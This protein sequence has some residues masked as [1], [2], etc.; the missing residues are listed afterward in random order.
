MWWRGN[1]APLFL[2]SA[3]DGGEWS[4]SRHGRLTP[5]ERAPDIHWKGGWVGTIAFL[6]AVENRKISCPCR[7]RTAAVQPIDRRYTHRCS[8][9]S[10]TFFLITVIMQN[11]HKKA[12]GLQVRSCVIYG[13][14][15]SRGRFSL[16]TLVSPASSH[17][18]NSS[19]SVNHRIVGHM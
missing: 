11:D 15:S 8:T 13:V 12:I 6:D 5:R 14:Q 19:M 3:L 1:I 17:S 4:A 18:T 7:N 10:K 16:S 2:T 9:K